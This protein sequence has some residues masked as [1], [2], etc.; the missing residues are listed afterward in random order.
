MWPTPINNKIDVFDVLRILFFAITVTH[1]DVYDQLPKRLSNIPK[2]MDR[3]QN[4]VHLSNTHHITCAHLYCQN[5]LSDFNKA[6]LCFTRHQTFL[7]KFNAAVHKYRGE[8]IL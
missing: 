5:D 4:K 2:A 3:V 7:R 6:A 8:L 1:R